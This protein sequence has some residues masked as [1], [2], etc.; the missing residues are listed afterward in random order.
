[1]LGAYTV[2]KKAVKFG[3]KRYG[4]PGAVASG[5]VAM[6]GYV[7]VR[8]ALKSSTNSDNVDSAI[9][10]GTIKDAVRERGLGAVTDRGTLDDA[11]REDEL[12][13]PIDI[14]EVQSSAA[15]ESDEM[16][17]SGTEDQDQDEPDDG[18]DGSND[19]E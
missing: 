19:G 4:L 5:S 18:Q 17:G 15:E 14:D 9:D 2:G 3:Y 13:T 6:A 12:G 10:A 8:R 16:T 7:I 11:I 1:M